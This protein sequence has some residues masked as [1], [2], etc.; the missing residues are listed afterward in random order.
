LGV[1][2]IFLSLINNNCLTNLN[3]DSNS[4]FYNKDNISSSLDEYYKKIKHV[5]LLNYK[6][7]YNIK[8]LN[9]KYFEK[10]ITKRNLNLTKF[11]FFSNDFF[12]INFGYII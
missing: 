8:F 3:L 2:N 4:H 5:N 11:N 12:D 1:Y 10:L 6:Y 7:N 9:S